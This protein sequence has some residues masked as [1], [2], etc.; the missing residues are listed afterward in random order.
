MQDFLFWWSVITTA[1]SVIFLGVSIW[2]IVEGRKQK[3][4]SNAQVKIWQQDANGV[5][6]ALI[7]II[8]DNLATR[9]TTTND[10]CN[11]I[12]AVQASSFALYQSLYE[13]RA[14]TEEEYKQQQKEFQEQLK[15]Q[16]VNAQA[17]KPKEIEVAKSKSKKQSK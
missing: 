2:Q 16:Q 8:Q 4:R 10:V 7:R 6:Q 12:W 9:Y 5:A 15:R 11:A 1:L 14:V 3:E 13:E 17:I